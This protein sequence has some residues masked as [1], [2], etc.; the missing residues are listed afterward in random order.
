MY[1]FLAVSFLLLLLGGFAFVFGRSDERIAAATFV[2]TSL[3]SVLIEA[4]TGLIGHDGVA[5]SSV[6]VDV[7]ALAGYMVVAVRSERFWPLWVAGLQLA[8][9]LTYGFAFRRIDLPPELKAEVSSFWLYPIALVIVIGT[10][11]NAGRRAV[12]GRA[13]G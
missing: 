2:C 11:R 10:S 1:D 13:I 12:E 4:R 6:V 9:I 8:M 3:A 5:V 7:L